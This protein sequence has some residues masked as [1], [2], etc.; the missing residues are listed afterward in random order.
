VRTSHWRCRIKNRGIRP[1]HLCRFVMVFK[2]HGS[3]PSQDVAEVAANFLACREETAV[4]GCGGGKIFSRNNPSHK[5]ANCATMAPYS[6][7]EV[8]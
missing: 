4:L 7:R 2:P 5:K 8:G 3:A 1:E 6:A